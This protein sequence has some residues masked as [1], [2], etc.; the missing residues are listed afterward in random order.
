MRPFPR[1]RSR[2][3]LSAAYERQKCNGH[4]GTSQTLQRSAEDRLILGVLGNLAERLGLDTVAVRI[5][6]MVTCLLT[7]GSA[8]ILY[9]GNVG[10][11]M[12]IS[13]GP[14]DRTEVV[15]PD[16]R[17]KT[18]H[19]STAD[20]RLESRILLKVRK[21]PGPQYEYEMIDSFLKKIDTRL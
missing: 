7:A 15:R 13:M 19:L 8:A 16:P 10:M 18:K 17:R 4:N 21:E 6:W 12:L 14:S 20:L 2:T 1:I 11:G 9:V 5:G 3:A